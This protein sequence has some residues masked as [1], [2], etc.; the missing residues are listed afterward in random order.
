MS[1][2]RT[3]R[4]CACRARAI[5]TTSASS[6]SAP[7]RHDPVAGSGSTTSRGRST[8]SRTSRRPGRTLTSSVPERRV[9]PRRHQEHLRRRPRRQRVRGHVDAPEE[10]W[11]EY[12]NSAPIEPLDLPAEIHDGPVS[13]PPPSSSP[14]TR[15]SPDSAPSTAPVVVLP[16]SAPTSWSSRSSCC[17]TAV[18]PTSARSSPLAPH[19][20]QAPIYAAVRAPIAEGGGYAW[21]ANRGIGRPVAESLRHHHGTGSAPGSTRSPPQGA[22]SC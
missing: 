7:S 13:A 10:S 21:F 5:T 16:H 15:E 9:Q 12:E 3:P 8:R 20:P 4:S 19:L 6:G 11:G 14:W 22:P 2:V 17:S 18:G 1:P